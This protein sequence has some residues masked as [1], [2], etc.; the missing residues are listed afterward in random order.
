MP[1]KLKVKPH[2]KA[3][4]APKKTEKPKVETIRPKLVRPGLRHYR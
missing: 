4:P 1:P 2:A 3:K